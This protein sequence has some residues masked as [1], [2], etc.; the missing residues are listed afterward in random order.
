MCRGGYEVDG[1]FSRFMNRLWEILFVGLLWLAASLPLVT[2][3]AATTAAYFAMA[4]CVRHRTGYIWREFVRSFR[5]N[6]RQALPLTVLFFVG[7][8]VFFADFWYLWENES[9]QNNAIFMILLLV[10]FLFAGVSLYVCPLL[11]RFEKK[12]LELLRISA[13]LAF[14]FLPVTVL[15]ML[16]IVFSAVA[17]YLMPWAVFVL[18]GVTLYVLSYPMEWIL[19]KLAPKAEQDGEEAEKWY[20]Q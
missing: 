15:L 6:F 20:Y 5:L 1:K 12:N 9:N 8:A 3:G 19:R 14:R 13:V 16:L 10:A 4:K 17:A 18:P 2:A 11:S 7:V